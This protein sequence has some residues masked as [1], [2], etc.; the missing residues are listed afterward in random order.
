MK[1][2]KWGVLSVSGHFKMRVMPQFR[3]SDIIVL[4]GIASRSIEKAE[5]ISGMF[6]E[7]KAYGSY[8]ELLKDKDIEAVYIPLPNHMH[9]EWTK[10]CADAGKH[11][12]CE[13]PFGLNAAETAE[14][15]SYAE[16]KGVL[17]M[18]AFMYRLQPAWRRA[19]EII[20]S[21]EIGKIITIQSVFCYNNTDPKNIRNI[22]EIGG[23]GIYDIG[24]YCINSSRFLTGLEPERAVSL[25]KRADDKSTDTLAS[26]MLDFGNLTSVFSVSTSAFPAQRVEVIGTGG[27]LSLELPFNTY[28]DVPSKLVVT[29]G[30]GTREVMF[31]PVDQYKIML[32]EFSAAVRG[33]MKLPTS[34]AD[35]INNMKVIDALFESEKNGRWI[36]L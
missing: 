27:R 17:V 19:K 33:E 34:S 30:L 9:A 11:V 8:E 29:G 12:L 22:K 25:V 10:K 4:G 36:S 2:V 24:C 20:E 26:A 32:H 31:E 21:G 6:P 16:K 15:I 13:K 1:K 35:A 3:K 7:S 18:E 23:G 5:I 28:N 14:A